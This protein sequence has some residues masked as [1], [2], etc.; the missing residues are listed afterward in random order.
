MS[1]PLLSEAF[2][3]DEEIIARHG[4]NFKSIFAKQGEVGVLAP[5]S[6]HAV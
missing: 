4:L 6:L 1:T 2:D 3:S 5:T